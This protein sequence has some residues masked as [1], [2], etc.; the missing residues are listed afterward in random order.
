MRTYGITGSSG[1]IGS[2]L[3]KLIENSNDNVI[4]LCRYP[5][6]Q[7]NDKYYDLTTTVDSKF[8]EDIDTIIHCAY[9]FSSSKNNTKEKNINYVGTCN[10]LAACRKYKVKKFI[11][12]SSLASYADALSNYG[13][14]KYAIESLV[15][16]FGGI[17]LRPG[18]VYGPK[19]KG[20]FL[21]LFSQVH[22]K[23][24][25]PVL[26]DGKYA[27]YLV[28]IDDLCKF[29]LLTSTSLFYDKSKDRL[30]SVANPKKWTFI[31]LIKEISSSCE[32]RPFIIHIPIGPVVGMLKLIERIGFKITYTSD[33]VI[34]LCNPNSQIDFT[35]LY[36]TQQSFISFNAAIL[37]Y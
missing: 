3:R 6:H 2:H 13:K 1:Y 19:P 16:E 7:L 18:L 25:I 34:S 22:S 15:L 28:H 5:D 33:N 31:D 11:Y 27:Q 17:V 10:L 24:I 4:G 37:T 12:I 26:G 20:A 14:V 36:N 32:R 23:K 21:K 8:L 29:I 30:F 35:S 9:D